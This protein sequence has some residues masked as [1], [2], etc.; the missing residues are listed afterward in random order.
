MNAYRERQLGYQAEVGA[1]AIKEYCKERE[2]CYVHGL[3]D[4]PFG[5]REYSEN[6]K[7]CDNR[8]IKRKEM[9]SNDNP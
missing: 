7:I 5:I 3:P 8:I 1:A 9:N 6:G 2:H 4:C